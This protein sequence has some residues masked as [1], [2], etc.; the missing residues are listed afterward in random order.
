[1]EIVPESET[2]TEKFKNSNIWKC[3]VKIVDVCLV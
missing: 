2:E 3:T 1:V